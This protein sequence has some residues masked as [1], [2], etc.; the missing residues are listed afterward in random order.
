MA[1]KAVTLSSIR[2]AGFRLNSLKNRLKNRRMFP[3]LINTRY[4]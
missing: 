1:K 3:H 4:R 2:R